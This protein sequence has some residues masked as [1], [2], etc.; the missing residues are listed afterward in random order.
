[1]TLSS[2][3]TG[4]TSS[5]SWLPSNAV[6][7]SADLIASGERS[8]CRARSRVAA[9]ATC[10]LAMDVPLIIPNSGSVPVGGRPIW[11][12]SSPMNMLS[13]LVTGSGLGLYIVK[14]CLSKVGGM[15]EMNTSEGTGTE[16][17]VTLPQLGR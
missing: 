14:D 17:I 6:V 8:G 3:I 2:F 13:V 5:P 16:F 10:G 11:V 4:W 12:R 9:P 15:V 7:V 1:M